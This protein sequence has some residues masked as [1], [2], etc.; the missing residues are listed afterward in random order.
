MWFFFFNEGHASYLCKVRK[1]LV[2]NVCLKDVETLCNLE[3]NEAL[4]C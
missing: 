2:E 4:E 1:E 3:I